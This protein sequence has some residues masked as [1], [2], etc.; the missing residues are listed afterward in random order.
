ML[1]HLHLPAAYQLGLESGAIAD[2]QLHAPSYYQDPGGQLAWTASV[3]LNTD[4]PAFLLPSWRPAT[5]STWLEIDLVDN[6]IIH[7]L[8]VQGDPD[9]M[10][11]STQ[12]QM[13][14]S[15]NGEFD[16]ATTEV[17]MPI[18]M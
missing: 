4:L 5:A 14:H 13:Q 7:A 11:F 10:A 1:P 6:H 12:L 16:P 17:N 15:L 2:W 8:L 18:L 3:R 9:E